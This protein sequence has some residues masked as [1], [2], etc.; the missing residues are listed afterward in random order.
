MA[1]DSFAAL[2]GQENHDTT[3]DP[4]LNAYPYEGGFEIAGNR[5]GLRELA[6]ICLALAD[7]PE[8]ADESRRLGNHYHFDE[9][10]AQ[11]VV[12]DG[13][14]PFAILYEPDL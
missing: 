1:R 13:S 12:Q 5:E 11:G 4:K 2:G 10:L 7:L 8:D 9:F 6:R 14:T 3:M